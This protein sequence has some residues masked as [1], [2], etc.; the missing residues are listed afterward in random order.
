[1]ADTTT[2]V[3]A[4]EWKQKADKLNAL[5]K[6]NPD[7]GKQV[8]YRSRQG[9]NDDPVCVPELVSEEMKENSYP[10]VVTAPPA[11]MVS[12]KYSWY[13]KKGW[14]ENAPQ[15]QGTR[16][17]A[18]EN[19]YQTVTQ[20]VDDLKKDK[21]TEVAT[22]QKQDKK[23]DQIIKL[24]TM[25]NARLGMMQKNKPSTPA[26]MSAST[27]ASLS[28]STSSSASTTVQQSNSQEGGNK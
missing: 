11:D 14:F 17:T 18:L 5:L 9:L 15:E 23:M 2:T 24:V 6:E 8:V 19:N 20:T 13:G 27:S 22:S 1:M 7:I 12:P 21:Q 4:P 3:T 26:S 16:I 28:A 25:T 10:D